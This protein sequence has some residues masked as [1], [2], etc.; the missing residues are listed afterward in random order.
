MVFRATDEN[1]LPSSA[2]ASVIEK[3][4]KQCRAGGLG[5]LLLTSQE[6]HRLV[7]IEE[8]TSPH[9]GLRLKLSGAVYSVT[10]AE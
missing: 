3:V 8:S 10:I 1:S 5:N 4:S 6:R 9:R 7:E 2:D